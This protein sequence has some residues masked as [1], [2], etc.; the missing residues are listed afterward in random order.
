MTT[1][2][3]KIKILSAGYTCF[4]FCD[5]ESADDRTIKHFS[6]LMPG[7]IPY[8]GCIEQSP[9]PIISEEGD[10][11]LESYLMDDV[12]IHPNPMTL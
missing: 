11:F 9:T 5:F 4:H 1:Y 12:I 3:L 8:V 6:L 10:A 7:E 2:E